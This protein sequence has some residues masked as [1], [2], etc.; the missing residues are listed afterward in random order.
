MNKKY[1][2]ICGE[3]H[4]QSFCKYPDVSESARTHC[5]DAHPWDTK[6][7]LKKLIEA[8]DILLDDK[9]YDGHGYEQIQIARE[10]AKTIVAS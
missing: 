10:R 5:Y 7:V 3:N 6:S 9:N 1:C 8:A 2:R 4:D